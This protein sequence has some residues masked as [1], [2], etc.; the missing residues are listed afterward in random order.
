MAS[1]CVWD[2]C[3]K[4]AMSGTSLCEIHSIPSERGLIC[5][6]PICENQAQDNYMCKLHWK[7][8]YCKI[9]GCMKTMFSKHRCHEH[10]N[11]LAREKLTPISYSKN[12]RKCVLPW[13]RNKTVRFKNNQSTYCL[14]HHLQ[15]SGKVRCKFKDCRQVI[16]S[17]T[18]LQYGCCD[19]HLN[20]CGF[21]VPI[22]C[23]YSDCSEDA[24][25]G[26]LCRQHLKENRYHS[27]CNVYGCGGRARK[28]KRCQ[29]HQLKCIGCKEWL[30]VEKGKTECD[31][32]SKI[33]DMLKT[34]QGDEGLELEWDYLD[35]SF[36]ELL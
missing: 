19:G 4:H 12:R 29:K 33:D 23:F 9:E 28:F 11:D 30:D 13:C 1:I 22:K 7:K 34:I 21:K 31:F 26:K 24:Y 36:F 25:R 3:Y 17:I 18:G 10:W 16:E 27:L 15:S 35:D 6:D 14:L 32:C 8:L 2:P 5:K 20:E